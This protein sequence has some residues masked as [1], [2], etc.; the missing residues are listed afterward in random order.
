MIGLFFASILAGIIAG[1]PFGAAGAMVADAALIHDKQRLKATIFAAVA[2]DTILAFLISFASSPV[3]GFLQANEP[4]FYM[5]AGTAI[6]ML[7]VFLGVIVKVQHK[8]ETSLKTIKKTSTHS[9]GQVSGPAS[10][11]FITLL[12]PGSIAT[13]LVIT[14]VFS[15]TFPVFRHHR[16]IFVSGI[17]I[18]SLCAFSPVGILFWMLRRKAKKHIKQL[19]YGLAAVLCLAGMYLLVN[20]FK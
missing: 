19:R 2:G 17:A 5:I 13:F 6:I 20:G 12:H 7:G 3:K 18:G 4:A 9:N 15:M 1:A 11:F 14:A 8:S 10:V 16:I